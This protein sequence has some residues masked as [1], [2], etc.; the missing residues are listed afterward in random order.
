MPT[1]ITFPDSAYDAKCPSIQR[2]SN[3]PIKTLAC[4]DRDR[5]GPKRPSLRSRE[6]FDIA[7]VLLKARVFSSISFRCNSRRSNKFPPLFNYCHGDV[8]ERIG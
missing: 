3:H 6:A 1:L 5:E 8:E 7:V 2:Q 4:T